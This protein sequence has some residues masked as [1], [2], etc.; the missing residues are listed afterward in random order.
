MKKGLIILIGVI[1][2]VGIM[3]GSFYNSLVNLGENVEAKAADIDVQLQRRADLIPN[4]IN[5]VKGYM[6]HENDVIDKITLARENLVNANSTADKANAN[7]ELTSALNNLFVIVEN[8]PD[9]KS[10]SNFIELQDELAGTENRIAIARKEY[11]EVVADYNKKIK[12]FPTNIIAGM[13]NF[14]SKDYFT[15]KEGADEVPQVNFN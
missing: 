15:A 14:D 6:E 11:N 12:S 8:Y 4:L 5:T 10:S 1:L 13:F 3:L 7:A 2:F 9:L